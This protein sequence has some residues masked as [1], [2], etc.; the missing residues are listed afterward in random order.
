MNSRLFLAFGLA[1]LLSSSAFTQTFRGG[2]NGNVTDATGAA[3]AGAEVQAINTA[4]Q[5][6][7]DT[8]TTGT[9]EFTFPDLPLGSYQ[10]TVA[11]S[12]F[13]KL[14]AENVPVEVGKVT[15]LR[16]SMKVAS[17]TQTVE[18]AASA[19][20]I[21][22]DTSTLNQVIPDKAVQDMPLNGRDFTQLIKLAPGVNGAGSINGA[23]IAQNNWQIDGADN[24]DA[25]HNSA[26][27]NQGGVSGVAGTLLPIDA[28]DQFSVQTNA[29]A[30]A[31]RNGGGS[32]NM[33]IKSGSNAVHGTLYYFNRNDALAANTP[34]APA[35]SAKPKLKNNQFG[36]SLGGPVVHDK[37]FYFITY[38]RQK[39]IVGNGNSA[40]EPSAAW[41]SQ[42]TAVL[43]RYGVAVNP[44][45]TNLLSFWPAR[46]RTGPATTNNFFSSD[47]SDN[48]SDNGVGKIDYIFNERNNIAFRYFVGTGAQ[49]APVGSPYH[50]Y[51]QVAPSRMQNYSLVYNSVITPKLVS[52]TLAGVNY[53]KQTFN[54]FNT[55]FNPIAAGLNTGVTSSGL[56]GSPDI[57]ISGFDEIGLTPPLGRIDTTGHLTQSLSYTTGRHQYRFGG[58]FRRARLDVFYQRNARGTFSFDGTQGPWANDATVSDNLKSLGDFLAGYVSS[59]SLQVGNMQDDYYMN[60]GAAFAQDTF[61]LNPNLTLNY[62]VRWEYFGPFYDHTNRFSVFIPSKGG[63][64]FVGK[65]IGSLYPSRKN[66]FAPR[67]GFAYSPGNAGKFVVRGSYGV[68]YDSPN[69]N[70]FG[71]NRPP[72]SGATGIIYNPAGPSP[73]FS[74]TRSNYTIVKDQL[75]FGNPTLPPGPYGVFSVDQGFK[76]ASLQNYS[77]TAQYQIANGV[78][79]EAGYVGSLGHHLLDVVDVNM[80]PP[81]TLG[82]AATRAAQN[83]LRP[84]YSQFPNFATINQVGSGANSHYNGFIASIRTNAWRGVTSK[85]SYTLGHAVDDASAVRGLTPT[86]SRNLRFDYGDASFDV[87]HTFTSYITYD[88]PSPHAGPKLLVRGWQLNSLMAFYTGLPFTVYAGKNISGTFENRDR[89][90]VTGNPYASNPSLTNGYVQWLNPAAFALPAAGTFGNAGR[91]IFR[92]PGFSDVD[93]SVFKNTPITERIKTQLRLELFNLFN[94]KNYPVPN[95]T[96]SSGSF[97]RISDTIGD[98][99]GATGIGAGEPFNVQLALKIVF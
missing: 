84:Y 22:T 16:L 62:G 30:E 45:S 13:D 58:E 68:Y 56:T 49:T 60:S 57:A 54:D 43:N 3:I 10:V 27:V 7:R 99:N 44:V 18:V 29:N 33:V 52:Q 9:G 72:N 31:G 40:T 12:G 35:G 94:R 17:Q 14:R 21:D 32:I 67:F 23:R 83:Q 70:A 65:D 28:I 15:G 42:A 76:N 97:G 25:W 96:F 88:L 36:S 38:E 11:H 26:A 48:Y 64:N 87:R 78:L 80:A 4:T 63:I 77:L 86:D 85:F 19:V 93:F 81:S 50:D 66:N 20:M 61:K 34:F 59:S 82:T 90:N 74:T 8:V 24:N 5:L 69:L 55:G 91:D 2:I 53:F 39:F 51:Y 41:V 47:N 1:A 46:G 71:D 92:G 89:I 98:Y 6:R 79:A 75:V 95:A 37:L 73:I